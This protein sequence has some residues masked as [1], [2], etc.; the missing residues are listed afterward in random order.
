MKRKLLQDPNAMDVCDIPFE[1][2]AIAR[3]HNKPS[4][5]KAARAILGPGAK[6]TLVTNR[7]QS[8]WVVAQMMADK[9]WR[10]Y[11]HPETRSYWVARFDYDNWRVTGV[12]PEM[13]MCRRD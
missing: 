5:Q 4:A 3:Y 13:H 9:T 6:P 11:G 8:A 1:Q 2:V 12:Y 10:F 7:F